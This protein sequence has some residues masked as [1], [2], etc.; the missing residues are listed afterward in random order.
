MAAGTSAM[1]GE[2]GE[3][4]RAGEESKRGGAGQYEA[5]FLEAQGKDNRRKGRRLGLL[6]LVI[7]DKKCQNYGGTLS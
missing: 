4:G 7:L 5:S 2:A 1:G 6:G 3:R